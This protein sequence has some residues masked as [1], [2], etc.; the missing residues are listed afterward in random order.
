MDSKKQYPLSPVALAFPDASPEAD[1]RLAASIAKYGQ[2]VPVSVWNGEILDGRRRIA[3]CAKAGVAPV[4]EYLDDD[5][6]PVQYAVDRNTLH[7]EMSDSQ[8]AWVAAKLSQLSPRGRP[9]RRQGEKGANLHNYTRKD[10]AALLR[11]GTRQ[12]YYA[13]RILSE[14]GPAVPQL[15][16]AVELGHVRVG[17]A[18]SVLDQDPDVQRRAVDLVGTGQERTVTRAVKRIRRENQSREA[19]ARQDNQ[20]RTA[21][22]APTLFTASL[23]ELC[24]LVPAGSVDAVITHPPHR[25]DGLLLLGDLAS[26]AAHAL[27]PTGVLVVVGNFFL[28]RRMLEKLAR[29]DLRW[30]GELD[31]LFEGPPARSGPPYRMDIHRKPILVYGKADFRL[32][33]GADLVRVPPP[34]ELTPGFDREEQGMALL[35]ARFAAS[36]QTVCDPMMQQ[37]AT[38]LGAREMRYTFIGSADGQTSVDRIWNRLSAAEGNGNF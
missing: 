24:D 12:V 21:V 5:I 1:A 14:D 30:L 38:A 23:A 25:E 6:D 10:A 36:G 7:R 32:H 2:R 27:R 29:P 20:P 22:E 37:A 8:K 19:L 15:R 28:L 17:D 16:R 31:L 4:F 35:A 3:A 33:G 26:F 18:C 13:A 11:V 9:R 34:D